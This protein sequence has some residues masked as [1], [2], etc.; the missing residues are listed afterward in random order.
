MKTLWEFEGKDKN[1]KDISAA[2]YR[3]NRKEAE[4]NWNSDESW[5]DFAGDCKVLYQT[6]NSG[7]FIDYASATECELEWLSD[8]MSTDS[9]GYKQAV[10]AALSVPP[11]TL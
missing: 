7:Q 4:G 9:A 3:Y 10:R 11:S 8:N 2:V 1:N 5:E 6:G